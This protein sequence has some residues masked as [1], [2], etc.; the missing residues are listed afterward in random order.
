MYRRTSV[1]LVLLLVIGASATL[2]GAQSTRT[3][4]KVSS[5]VQLAT[6]STAANF[7]AVGGTVTDAGIVTA[8]PG[9]RGAEIDQLTVTAAPTG[10]PLALTGTTRVFFVKGTQTSK[11]AL[12][13]VVAPDGSTTYTG[14]GQFMKGTGIYKRITGKFTF[15]GS[16]PKGASVVTLQATGTARY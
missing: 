16:T 15:T 9:G 8:K 2:A 7:P 13:A 10:G 4:H 14:S 1:A 6:I 11:V 12:Q 3:N 5:T